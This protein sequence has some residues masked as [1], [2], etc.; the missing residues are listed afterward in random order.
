MSWI[1]LDDRI[2]EHP[3]FVRAVRKAGSPAVHLWLGLMS[4]CKQHLSDGVIPLD[5]M[6]EVSGPTGRWRKEALQALI[7]EE[8]VERL[9]R[10]GVDGMALRIHDYLDWND[11]RV[12][13]EARSDARKAAA[14]ARRERQAR[15]DLEQ[16][17]PAG[18]TRLE[19]DKPA[20]RT[21]LEQ[22]ESSDPAG[23]S[24]RDPHPNPTQPNPLPTDLEIPLYPPRS[25]PTTLTLVA[26][27]AASQTAST[28]EARRGKRSKPRARSQC[29][30]DLKPDETTAAEAWRLGFSTEQ[31][32]SVV[33]EF[34]DYWRGRGDLGAD[35][36][37]TLRNR[38]RREAERL[39]LKP[40]K[41]RDARWSSYQQQ[42][43]KANEPVAD[44]VPPPPEFERAIG[45]LFRG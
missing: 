31:R 43:R 25:Q 33:A 5:M 8:L 11:S 44:A 32:D 10:G 34:I 38:L 16:D 24:T 14:R 23:L 30:T 36:Q 9:D 20:G 15:S 28:G 13:V 22:R 2:L 17:K 29:P 21:D 37:A 35:W 26:P 42:L 7:D 19:Q 40:R 39:A 6:V 45:G 4:W 3:K 18:R 12:E 27:A 1:I 41:P